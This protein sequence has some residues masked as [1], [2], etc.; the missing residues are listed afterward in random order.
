MVSFLDQG[1]LHWDLLSLLL[2]NG[3]TTLVT[4]VNTIYLN[5]SLSVLA[6]VK[7]TSYLTR[8]DTNKIRGHVSKGPTP[9]KPRK[10]SYES[11]L[12]ANISVLTKSPVT[13]QPTSIIN[14]NPNLPTTL[15]PPRSPKRQ[16]NHNNNKAFNAS[17]NK[18]RVITYF[19]IVPFIPLFISYV[20]FYGAIFPEQAIWILPFV[21]IVIGFIFLKYIKMLIISCDGWIVV[22]HYLEAKRDICCRTYSDHSRPHRRINWRRSKKNNRSNA[23]S[24]R[25]ESKGGC[26]IKSNGYKGLKYKIKLCYLI[27]LKPILNYATAYLQYYY[28]MNYISYILKGLTIITCI[29]PIQMMRTIHSMLKP[30]SKMSHTHIKMVIVVCLSPICQLQQA[31]ISLIFQ[32]DIIPETDK[33]LFINQDLDIKYQWATVYGLIICVEM[34]IISII[35]T[36]KAFPASDL[37][38]WDKLDALMRSRNNSEVSM[39]SHNIGVTVDS[40]TEQSIE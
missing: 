5:H 4:L 19:K 6:L 23:N 33:S 2:I 9:T 1:L 25:K 3:L 35:I 22:R 10:K 39:N 17:W 8:A 32:L 31:F 40:D 24:P 27:L 20:A 30:Y 29:I 15:M 21:N 11:N 36:W 28:S 38:L 26:C 7:Q 14:T 37:M 13:T 18:N 16:H 34:F 12:S